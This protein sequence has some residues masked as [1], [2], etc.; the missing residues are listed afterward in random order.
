MHGSCRG[1]DTP[2][3]HA[4]LL[5]RR[6]SQLATSAFKN[7][8]VEASRAV[9]D[10]LKISSTEKHAG[11][12]G[13]RSSISACLA[14][15]FCAAPFGKARG[16]SALIFRGP[17]GM[18]CLQDYVK[19]IVFGGLDGIITTFAVVAS[20][21]GALRALRKACTSLP[22]GP[23]CPPNV[24]SR[25]RGKRPEPR[26]PVDFL[27]LT[28]HPLPVQPQPSFFCNGAGANLGVEASARALCATRGLVARLLLAESWAPRSLLP[29]RGIC[30]VAR[31]R[32][33]AP[34]GYAVPAQ[35]PQTTRPY[36][37]TSL[38]LR[39][40]APRGAVAAH[41]ATPHSLV[42][43]LAPVRHPSSHP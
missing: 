29:T 17:A 4:L 19:P 39:Y 37:T 41:Q 16:A 5:R 27:S 20:V 40:R 12:D 36:P 13:V 18:L 38:R 34:A 21:N 22:R 2:L 33:P 24:P 14:V 42:H 31:P 11:S 6:T 3:T 9:H 23:V 30:A 32:Y 26:A 10:A 15:V 43:T 35:D 8:D 28:L 7:G 1:G 25:L